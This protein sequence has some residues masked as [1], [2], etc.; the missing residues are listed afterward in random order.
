M[1]SPFAPALAAFALAFSAVLPAI[2]V[3]PASAATDWSNAG[4]AAPVAPAPDDKQMVNEQTVIVGQNASPPPAARI[5][6]PD[7]RPAEPESLPSGYA[8][9]DDGGIETPQGVVILPEGVVLDREGRELPPDAPLPPGFERDGERLTTPEGLVFVLPPPGAAPWLA[10]EEEETSAEP[11]APQPEKLSLS[12]LLPLTNM[13][14][15]ENPPAPE[16]KT[17]QPPTQAALPKSGDP[18][19]IPEDAAA[20]NDLSFLEGC[21]VTDDLRGYFGVW[22]NPQAK[23][24]KHRAKLCFKPDGSGSF[25]SDHRGKPCSGPARAQFGGDILRVRTR[26]A[27][28]RGASVKF[29]PRVFECRGT[30]ANTE[31]FIVATYREIG[32]KKSGR[33]KFRRE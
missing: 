11:E 31:C 4:K 7:G 33:A 3:A 12:S 20:K 27:H 32:R 24:E 9:R 14:G 13:D 23:G 18:F 8:W 26:E 22:N 5:E 1:R 2:P 19:R 15:S 6:L 16:P 28:C 21:W 10:E 30:A 25:M 17:A 29:A